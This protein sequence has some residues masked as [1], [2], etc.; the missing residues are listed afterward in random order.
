MNV[1]LNLEVNNIVYCCL[2]GNQGNDLNYTHHHIIIITYNIK[3][4]FNSNAM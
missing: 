3:T 4:A 1:K 2:T